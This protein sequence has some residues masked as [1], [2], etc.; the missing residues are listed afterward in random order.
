MFTIKAYSPEGHVCIYEATEIK[1]HP[2]RQMVEYMTPLIPENM[3]CILINGEDFSAAYIENYA[4]K[5]IETLKDY[6]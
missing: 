1:I 4:G 6:K 2:N 3:Q 5:T